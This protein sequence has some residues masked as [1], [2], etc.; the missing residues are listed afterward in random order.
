[1]NLDEKKKATCNFDGYEYHGINVDIQYNIVQNI[2]VIN[3]RTLNYL[4]R[5][6]LIIDFQ[7]R[8]SSEKDPL[9]SNTHISSNAI[10]CR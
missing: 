6:V 9:S 8:R 4:I 5:P 3:K 2:F 7:L 1:M 10:L